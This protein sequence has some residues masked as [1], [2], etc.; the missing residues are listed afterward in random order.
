MID[1]KKG[2]RIKVTRNH[3]PNLACTG[4][5]GKVFQVE[6]EWLFINLDD[7]QSVVLE[8]RE[9]IMIMSPEPIKESKPKKGV[10]KNVA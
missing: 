4:K 5:C 9:V 6:G 1:F 3:D 7:G 10:K 2:T 8:K